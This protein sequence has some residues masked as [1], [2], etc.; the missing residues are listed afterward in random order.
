MFTLS[1]KKSLLL[2]SLDPN[3]LFLQGPDPCYVKHDVAVI[4]YLVECLQAS[5]VHSD[6]EDQTGAAGQL[7]LVW[8]EE[9]TV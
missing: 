4:T 5:G 6:G 3:I 7:Y 1:Y 9:E 8:Q 2:L